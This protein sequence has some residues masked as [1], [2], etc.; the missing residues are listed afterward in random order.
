MPISQD[1]KRSKGADL[2]EVVDEGRVA[3]ARLDVEERVWH[4]RKWANILGS[5]R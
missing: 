4:R 2:L 1:P 3:L 5:K